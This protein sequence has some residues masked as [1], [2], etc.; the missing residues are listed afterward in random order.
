M[1]RSEVG[2]V[3]HRRREDRL[4]GPH[5]QW[6]VDW[7]RTAAKKAAEHHIMIDFHG[8]FKPDGMRRT[9]PNVLTREG[10]MGAEYNKWSGRETP[11]HEPI[12]PRLSGEPPDPNLNNVETP[13]QGLEPTHQSRSRQDQLEVRPQSRPQEVWLQILFQ[14]V[15]DL[16]VRQF[17]AF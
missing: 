3:G 2:E 9:F 8:A 6:M 11:K 17:R 10:V 4:H 12:V 16:G 7:Y 15:E 1:P 5:R 14:A 13:S